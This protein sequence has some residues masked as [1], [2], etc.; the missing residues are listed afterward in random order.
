MV[1]EN[2]VDDA[3]VGDLFR[4]RLDGIGVEDRRSSKG[5]GGI[6]KDIFDTLIDRNRRLI[7]LVILNEGVSR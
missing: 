6:T 4:I 5:F 7:L 3:A 1:V 2:A